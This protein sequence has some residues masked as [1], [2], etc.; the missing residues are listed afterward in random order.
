VIYSSFD[1]FFE[2]LFQCLPPW[3][4][5]REH[6]PFLEAGGNNEFREDSLEEKVDRI[7]GNVGQIGRGYCSRCSVIELR[8]GN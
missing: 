5:P 4:V 8:M 1:I 3:Q 6:L 7:I 2:L